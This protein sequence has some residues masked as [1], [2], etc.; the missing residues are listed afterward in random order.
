MKWGRIAAALLAFGFFLFPVMGKAQTVASAPLM[1]VIPEADVREVINKYIENFRALNYESLMALFSKGAVENR[2]LPYNDMAA[3]YYKMFGETQQLTYDVTID[4]VE[5]YTNSAFAAGRDQIVQTL[6]KDGGM[7]AYR[8][9]IQ[10]VLVPE[11]G[12]LKIFGL[13]YGNEMRDD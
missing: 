6:K 8:G 4:T 5:T 3:M 11:A 12:S 1:P 2:M 9:K 7:R 10:W 13:N